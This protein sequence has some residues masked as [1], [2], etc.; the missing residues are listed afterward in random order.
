MERIEFKP[1]DP[2][3]KRAETAYLDRGNSHHFVKGALAVVAKLAGA[4]DTLW[5]P[6]AEIIAGRGQRVLNAAEGSAGQIRFVGLLGLEDALREDS[7]SVV[8]AIRDSGIRIVMVTGDNAI[9]ARDVAEAVGISGGVCSPE[10]LHGDLSGDA[11]ECG[12]FAGV[13]PEDK[14]RLVRGNMALCSQ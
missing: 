14:F 5:Q 1:F 3:T 7:T 12:I 2:A 4:A 11:L 8:S 10:K 13:F 9:T 6:Q